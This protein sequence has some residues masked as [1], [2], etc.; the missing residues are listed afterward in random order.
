MPAEF[1]RV[2]DAILSEIPQADAFIDDILVFT[3]GNEIEQISA[4]KKTLRKLDRENMSLKLTKGQFS[5]KECECLG[6][7]NT[8]SGIT[9]FIRKTESIKSLQAPKTVSQIKS[10]MGSIHSLHKY[11]PALAELSAS[12]HPLLSKK[13]DYIWTNECQISFDNLKKTGSLHIGTTAF[14]CTP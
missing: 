1:Q 12:L 14:R 8:C 9:P 11:L 6:H 13:N 10:F 7:K 3:K 5:R 2:M 4:V